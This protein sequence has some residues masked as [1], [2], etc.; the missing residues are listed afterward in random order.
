M[1][2]IKSVLLTIVVFSLFLVIPLVSV[3]L[4]EASQKY[5][6]T[7][8]GEVLGLGTINSPSLEQLRW[9][10]ANGYFEDI[11]VAPDGSYYLFGI[12]HDTMDADM[13]AGEDIIEEINIS[14]IDATSFVSRYNADGSY[15]WTYVV[16]NSQQGI[17]LKDIDTTPSGELVLFGDFEVNTFDFDLTDGE[18][19]RTRVGN[20]NGFI[21]V[22][23]SNGTYNNTYLIGQTVGAQMDIVTGKIDQITGDIY[24]SIHKGTGTS[25]D[26]DP[27]AGTSLSGIGAGSYLVKLNSSFA[28]SWSRYITSGYTHDIV[29]DSQN[30]NIYM[31][32][33]FTGT[34][35]F[36]NSGSGSPDSRTATGSDPDRSLTKYKTDGSYEWTG[37]VEDESVMWFIPAFTKSM[38]AVSPDTGNVYVLHRQF[39]DTIDVDFGAGVHNVNKVNT[40]VRGYDPSPYNPVLLQY[41]PDAELVSATPLVT[42]QYR[43]DPTNLGFNSEG[44]MYLAAMITF[45]DGTPVDLD[46]SPS[47]SHPFTPTFFSNYYYSFLSKT[48][49]NGVPQWIYPILGGPYAAFVG[50]DLHNDNVY[51][52][53][54]YGAGNMADYD[55]APGAPVSPPTGLTHIPVFGIY[56][57]TVMTYIANLSG[58]LNV[59]DVASSLDATVASEVFTSPAIRTVRLLDDSTGLALSDIF[60]NLQEIRDWT[61]VQGQTSLAEEKV[62]LGS[63]QGNDGV[64]NMNAWIPIDDVNDN[65]VVHCPNAISIAE[66]SVSCPNATKIPGNDSSLLKMEISGQDYWRVSDSQNGGYVSSSEV[67]TPP[68]PTPTPTVSPSPTASLSPTSSPTTTTSPTPSGSATPTPT[69]TTTDTLFPTFSPSPTP[70]DGFVLVP[71]P[72]QSFTSGDT[73][74]SCP[75]IVTFAANKTVIT[76]GT[77][78]ILSWSVANATHVDIVPFASNAPFSGNRT[79]TISTNQQITLIATN[80]TCVREKVLTVTVQPI[81]PETITSSL[82][83][84]FAAIEV[85]T[86]AASS[87]APVVSS[88]HNMFSFGFAMVDRLR[89]RYPWGVVYDSKTKKP[90][91]RAIVRAIN[92]E[93]KQIVTSVTDALGVFRIFLKQG[94]YTITVTKQGYEFPSKLITTNDDKQFMNVY[95]GEEFTIQTDG[96]L[97]LKSFP[98]DPAG[99]TALSSL[100]NLWIRVSP[101]LEYINSTILLLGIG[102]SLYTV[103]VNPTLP[104]F[105][106]IAFYL[107]LAVTKLLLFQIP[108][109]GTVKDEK[110]EKVAGMEIGLFDGE[111]KNLV[112]TTFTDDKG[113]FSFYAKNDEYTIKVLDSHYELITDSVMD[114]VRVP[115]EGGNNGGR[116][117]MTDL[118]VRKT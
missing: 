114:G 92:T 28:F 96:E 70:S 42:G 29:I 53:G 78:I 14:G 32:G 90:L 109:S 81:A 25:I 4:W 69:P 88:S 79:E 45:A 65:S 97:V 100:S 52:S 7:G 98:M 21:T 31:Y 113:Q 1:K 40:T 71:T 112:T 19:I 63:I 58:S 101:Y 38:M 6:N 12:Y 59:I 51:V 37:V 72:T 76:P 91:G 33:R 22:I 107:G 118:K 27:G 9:I 8:G 36:N 43:L 16:A 89:R 47:G 18:D 20:S 35:N 62:Y 67:I 111:F 68:T 77:E 26:F 103:I 44:D 34:F 57:E 73:T 115:K 99:E 93:T 11:A 74:Q 106:L 54:R 117:I 5:D 66:V 50:L 60:T 23:N 95:H 2:L 84:G 56:S 75:T 86:I 10:Y 49:E 13:T 24:I 15:A 17:S 41:T 85:A 39:N 30:Q 116:V 48:N 102:T 110:G 104:N 55:P 61:A 82:V 46:W 94:T 3:K 87:V 108:T 80:G 83:L 64:S 105:L